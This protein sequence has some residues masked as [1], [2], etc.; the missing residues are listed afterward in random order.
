[1]VKCRQFSKAA[2]C[3]LAHDGNRTPVAKLVSPFSNH[4]T[5]VIYLSSF[6]RERDCFD[7]KQPWRNFKFGADACCP[8]SCHNI[9]YATKRVFIILQS[10]R[11]N[12]CYYHLST[13]I[14]P[15]I[16]ILYVIELYMFV[17]FTD[18]NLNLESLN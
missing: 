14:I 1:M 11:R 12:S 10:T 4:G 16:S 7:C 2:I 9:K 17:R 18:W 13:H 6:F 8:R 3:H 15:H 5:G